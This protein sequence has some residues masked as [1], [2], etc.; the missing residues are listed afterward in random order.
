MT[1][2]SVQ[3]KVANMPVMLLSL[4]W[5]VWFL[6]CGIGGCTGLS[7]LAG[8]WSLLVDTTRT[9]GVIAIAI[10]ATHFIY[11]WVM[12]SRRSKVLAKPAIRI[13]YLVSSIGIATVAIL[14]NAIDSQVPAVSSLYILA[15]MNFVFAL[16]MP[17]HVESNVLYS[18]P[19]LSTTSPDE[20][21]L[22][23]RD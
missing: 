17:M 22:N 12:W 11:L 7:L 21:A 23:A 5:R 8:L 10:S 18:A 13:G 19:G 6:G 3:S 9:P 15:F 14:L 16:F 4:D 1:V 2:H 20:D